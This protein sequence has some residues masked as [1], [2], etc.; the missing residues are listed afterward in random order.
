MAIIKERLCWPWPER[1]KG[2]IL[3]VLLQYISDG[4]RI[5]EIASGSG[6]HA[7]HFARELPFATWIPSDID[8]T[9]LRSISSW[10]KY[11]K[12]KNLDEAINLDV[13]ETQWNIN[14]VDIINN[15]DIIFNA[16]MIH[17][18]PWSC[19]VGLLAGARR[20]LAAG[21]LLVLYGPFMIGGQHTA[22]SNADFDQDLRSRDPSWGVR[23][24][25]SILEAARGFE[26]LKRH[27]MPAN[28]Q[29]IVLQRI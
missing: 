27:E 16:N 24:L 2:P 10:R 8:E 22:P 9:N 5:L 4:S 18:T 21:G 15:I 17:I 26:L 14:N 19:C 12:L 6:Q 28:N 29:T 25:E 20:H 1:N 7:V 13:C 3:E 11:K 23:N